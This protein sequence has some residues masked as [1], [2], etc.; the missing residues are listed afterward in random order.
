MKLPVRELKEHDELFWWLLEGEPVALINLDAHSDMAMFDGSLGIGNFISKL[1]QMGKVTEVFWVR[2]PRSIDFE[3]GVHE[4][5]M[6]QMYSNSL[7]LA[8]SLP[9]PF[10]FVQQAYLTPDQMLSPRPVR[11]TVVSTPDRLPDLKDTPWVLSVDF[12]YFSCRN[13]N[14]GALAGFVRI[15]GPDFIG[16]FYRR[17]KAIR[18][19]N[20]W[21]AFAQTAETNHP[22]ITQAVAGGLFPEYTATRNEIQAKILAANRWLTGSADFGLCRG[23]YSVESL[24]S[25]FTGREEH[26]LILEY[27]KLWFSFLKG[28]VK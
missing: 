5:D 6:G 9:R 3:D 4:F 11:M 22:G 2:D 12:D 8:A 17:G 20:E 14:A 10:Y 25:G 21:D 16:D 26:K 28:A 1:I 24:G 19:K 18:T 13:P 7:A 23:L 15:L 27:V